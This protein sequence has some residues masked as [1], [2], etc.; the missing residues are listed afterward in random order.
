MLK[1]T[2]HRAKGVSE[3]A[4]HIKH[5]PAYLRAKG[6]VQKQRAAAQSSELCCSWPLL[7]LKCKHC[8]LRPLQCRGGSTGALVWLPAYAYSLSYEKIDCI[9]HTCR[10]EQLCLCCR[11][12]AEG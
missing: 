12:W 2:K 6:G 9:V 11:C 5:L 7:S 3:P 10:R 8:E 1:A 4:P